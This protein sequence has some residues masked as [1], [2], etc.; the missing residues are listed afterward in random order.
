MKNYKELLEKAKD[1]YSKCVTDAE[2]RR[3]EA[4]FPELIESTNEQIKQA[5]LEFFSAGAKNNETTCDIPDYKIVSLLEK[6]GKKDSQVIFPT[7]TFD[8][9]LALECCMKEVEKDKKLYNQLQSLHNRVHG[10]YWLNREEEQKETLCNKCRKEQYC[11]SCQ[12]ITELR[13]CVLEHQ[14]EQKSNKVEPKYKVGDW[15]IYK[16]FHPVFIIVNIVNDKY[17]I[18][19]TD[20][21]A[22]GFHPIDLI[23]RHWHL[24][25]VQD[26]KDG[27]V[28]VHGEQLF[29]FKRMNTSNSFYA[30]CNYHFTGYGNL[31]FSDCSYSI[32]NI[33][34]ATK[35]QRD[36]LE[37]EITKAGYR[38][39]REERKLE[40][41]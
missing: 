39:N 3:L 34:P 16:G 33:H 17:E 10:A 2:K 40:K 28:L 41:I 26:T 36:R 15:I 35:E 29:L 6:Q 37:K 32:D 7:F 13:R 12:D 22:K 38:W 23:D 20:N 4:I 31:S 27:D 11:H 14:C 25:A 1:A 18:E 24:W 5:L 21:G 8:D 19:F 9:I 30:H